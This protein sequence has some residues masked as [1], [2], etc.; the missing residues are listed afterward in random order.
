MIRNTD[1]MKGK[2]DKPM[3]VV[4]YVNIPPSLMDI[5]Q[6]TQMTVG[7]YRYRIFDQHKL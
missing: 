6:Q 7:I 4:E 2:V 3:L 1:R 5:P